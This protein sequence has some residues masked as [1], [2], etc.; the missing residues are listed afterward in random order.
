[1]TEQEKAAVRTILQACQEMSD[2]QRAYF[3]GFAD[4]LAEAKAQEQSK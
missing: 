1:M 4:G 2:V 3:L